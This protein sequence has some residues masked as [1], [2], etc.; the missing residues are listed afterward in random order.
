[1]FF[2]LFGR[3]SV[4]AFGVMEIIELPKQY[5][6]IFIDNR[7]GFSVDNNISV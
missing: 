7:S 3:Y 5:A 6:D 1:V 2:K 4:D